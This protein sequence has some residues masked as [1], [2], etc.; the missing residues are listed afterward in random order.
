MRRAISG[1]ACVAVLVATQAQAGVMVWGVQPSTG[2]IITVNPATGALTGSFAAPDALSPNHIIN[3]LTIAEGGS[4]LLYVNGGTNGNNLY[5]L[6]PNTGT[7]LS[8]ESL[9]TNGN[10]GFRG[11]LSFESGTTDSIFAIDNGA[12]V[13]RQ[14]G[15]GGSLTN[16]TPSGATFPG[17]LGGD[18]NGRLFLFRSNQIQE[19]STTVANTQ[20]N[21]FPL[22]P[23]SQGPQGLAFDGVSLYLSDGVGSLFTLNPNTGALLNQV[24][25]QGGPLSAL[26]AD[27]VVPE[28]TSLAIFGIGALGMV[29]MRRRKRTRR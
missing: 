23:G 18:D 24:T 2:S 15:F 22:P 5:R 1:L 21:S 19:F 29:G 4:T 20:L 17:A 13:D 10:P 7:V 14:A 26:A 9:P 27:D 12:P 25:V 3:G 28:P 8:I 11:G 6:N 16:W